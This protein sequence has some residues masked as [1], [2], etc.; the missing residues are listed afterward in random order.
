M[1]RQ[2]SAETRKIAH[3]K[4][5]QQSLAITSQGILYRSGGSLRHSNMY[6]KQS[7]RHNNSSHSISCSRTKLAVP[8]CQKHS[9][10]IFWFGE[11]SI[12]SAVEMGT[13]RFDPYSAVLKLALQVAHHLAITS[14]H[15]VIRDALSDT[16]QT[17]GNC[18]PTSFGF[19]VLTLA[20]LARRKASHA[21][22]PDAL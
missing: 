1:S 4:L 14:I 5:A 13:Q 15:K 2:L 16:N 6:S 20:F 3:T 10:E 17:S 8:F 9:Y 12:S 7:L 19:I 11:R 18:Q 21:V 22:I